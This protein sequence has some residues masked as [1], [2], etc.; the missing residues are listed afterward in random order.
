VNY[1]DALQVSDGP[2]KGKWHYVSQNRR[3]GT[4]PVGYCSRFNGDGTEKSDEEYHA[5]AHETADEARECFRRYLLDGSR[6]ESYSDWTGC[7]YEGCDEPTKKGLTQRT[8][9]GHG[10]ALCDKHRTQEVLEELTGPIGQI[11]A[12]Y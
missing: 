2:M 7:E 4:H 1:Y 11:V 8:P 5:H 3:E 9:L 10:F 12:S 6:E